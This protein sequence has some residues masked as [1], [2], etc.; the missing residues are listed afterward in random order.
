MLA[1]NNHISDG[2]RYSAKIEIVGDS[3]VGKLS[4]LYSLSHISEDTAQLL[5][6]NLE[7]KKSN[8]PSAGDQNSIMLI[9][10]NYSEFRGR[11]THLVYSAV[12][13]TKYVVE[14][15]TIAN[16]SC[17]RSVLNYYNSMALQKHQYKRLQYMYNYDLVVLLFHYYRPES[18]YFVRQLEEAV[19]PHQPRLYVAS[20]IY[21]D[22]LHIPN[23]DIRSSSPE[24]EHDDSTYDEAV[25]HVRQERI[26]PVE[27]L[28]SFSKSS[29]GNFVHTVQ[30]CLRNPIRAIPAGA[31]QISYMHYFYLQMTS[32]CQDYLSVFL[33][34]SSFTTIYMAYVPRVVAG[35]IGVSIAWSF[36]RTS[37]VMKYLLG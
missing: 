10:G 4:L 34:P 28:S 12:L 6:A 21:R 2:T 29:V 8:S 15:D 31:E 36:V 24:L 20:R 19:K 11:M 1:Y 33:H 9:T 26:Y 7:H 23:M 30:T 37:P 17:R 32:L 16:E 3:G 27:V 5:S 22:H 35:V 14:M 13:Q 18:F 25:E